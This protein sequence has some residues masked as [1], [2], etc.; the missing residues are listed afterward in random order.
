MPQVELRVV[1]GKQTGSVISLPTGKF[2]IG[3]EQDCHLRPNSDLISRHHCAFTVDEYAVQ[4][5]DL[6]STNGTIVN[7]E[8]IRGAV[9]LN[10]GDR[11]T[12]GKLDFEVVIDGVPS[13]PVQ[14]T[15][16]GSSDDT[17]V[18]AAQASASAAVAQTLSD[19][20]LAELAAQAAVSAAPVDPSA[21]T[22]VVEM[23]QFSPPPEVA[24]AAAGMPPGYP[25]ASPAPWGMP[26]GYPYPGGYPQYPPGMPYGFGYPYPGV[27]QAPGMPGYPQ[28][29]Y[30]YPAPMPAAA[31]APEAPPPAAAAKAPSESALAVK[32][33]DPSTTGA[34]APA[35]AP[36]KPADGSA[37]PAKNIPT[38]AAELINNLLQRRP[39]T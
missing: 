39:K 26:P 38:A 6:G 9:L 3:R 8:R 17:G 24:A 27:P 11:V 25:Q 18:L 14:E 19:V 35:P 2:L 23:P 29:G 30:P 5:R 37:A 16:L 31:A 1:S 28:P 34:K 13:T 12:V 15:I 32:L 36:P 33:P 7:G 22:A 10:P 4:V 21:P 20:S